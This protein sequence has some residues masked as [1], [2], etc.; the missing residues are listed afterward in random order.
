MFLRILV[1]E[2]RICT[3]MQTPHQSQFPLIFQYEA[4][5]STLLNVYLL[6]ILRPLFLEW[7]DQ[8]SQTRVHL[9]RDNYLFLKCPLEDRGRY[10]WYAYRISPS[11]IHQVVKGTKVAL[12]IHPTDE[13][14]MDTLCWYSVGESLHTDS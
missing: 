7:L 9:S 5:L 6:Q 11:G 8:Y 14:L 12:E 4:P 1:G 2:D 3:Q 13:S 10:T